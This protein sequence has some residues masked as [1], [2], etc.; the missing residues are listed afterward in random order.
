[1]TRI[2]AA[3]LRAPASQA[4]CQA[5]TDAGHQAW[6]VGGCVRDALMDLPVGDID[7]ATDAH[8]ED[9]LRHARAAGLKAIATGLDHGTITVISAGQP[10]EVT[11]F[12]R[13]VETDGRHAVV[14]FSDRMEEDARRR[15]FTMN[16]L[17]A[18]PDGRVR[19]PLG[20]GLA[21][22]AAR[23]LRFIE[24]PARRIREDY[25]RILR[26]FRFHARFADPAEGFDAETLAAIAENADGLEGLSRERVGA[27]ITKLLATRDPVREVATMA[28]IHI[29]AGLV[30]GADPRA[31]GPLVHLQ[32]A[33]G[34][35]PDWR[36]RLAALTG[37][38]MTAPLRLSQKDANITR[39]MREEAA[40]TRGP[41][42]LGYRHGAEVAQQILLL[43]AALLEMPLDPSGLAAARDGA[44]Q[45]FPIGARDLMPRYKG[46]ALGA[47]LR[48][49][50][51]RWIASGFTLDREALL[52]ES[53]PGD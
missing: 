26:F 45:S 31:L 48:Q 30:P 50:E 15:D 7:I 39:L 40:E 41:G 22:L 32:Q 35:G 19:D 17:Y 11:T 4:V 18:A 44:G 46:P 47:R 25:L 34:L 3:W 6:F 16:A 43:R 2:T 38:D 1:M 24:D 21:D 29:L 49:L 13:D 42:E 14:A 20:L 33:A 36:A 51:A 10:H 37:E 52:E 9:T 28:Q 12:R 8:P 27:E 5:L 53:P 23:R